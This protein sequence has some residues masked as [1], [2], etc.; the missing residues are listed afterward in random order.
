MRTSIKTSSSD[1]DDKQVIAP[2]LIILRV[3]DRR[4]LTSNAV[5]SGNID[6]IRFKSQGETTAGEVSLSD[7][8]PTSSMGPDGETPDGPGVGVEPET[9]I[10]EVHL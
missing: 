1:H 2:F 3:A 5:T 8:Y 10:E 9:A 6:S 7:V 4:A